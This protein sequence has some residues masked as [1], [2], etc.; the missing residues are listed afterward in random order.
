MKVIF[1]TDVKGV[2]KRGEQKEV[3]DGY[4]RNFLAAKGTA[5]PLTDPKAKQIMSQLQAKAQAHEADIA[6]I[7]AAA[8]ALNGREIVLTGKAQPG[9]KLFGAIREQDIADVLGIDKKQ[10]KI[11]P[12]KTVGT[13]SVTV[14]FGTVAKA[15]VTVVV[16]AA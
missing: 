10:I 6:S 9:G 7:K 14:S 8:A 15:V 5:V 13:H 16:T 3:S 12:I 2:A 4:Y 1:V 11:D